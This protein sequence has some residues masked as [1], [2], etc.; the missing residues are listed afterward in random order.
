MS[1]VIR[2]CTG[3]ACSCRNHQLVDKSKELLATLVRSC[4]WVLFRAGRT[5][6]FGAD[7]GS[8]QRGHDTLREGLLMVD[9]DC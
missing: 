3:G 1:H 5:K 7:V 2:R 6:S 8:P 4:F 9:M